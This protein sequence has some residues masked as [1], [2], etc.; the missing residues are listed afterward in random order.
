MTIFLSLL[1]EEGGMRNEEQG[2]RSKEEG[3]G[4]RGWEEAKTNY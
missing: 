3:E 1:I 4:G 2:T